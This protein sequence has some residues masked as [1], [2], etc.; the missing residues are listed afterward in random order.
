MRGPPAPESEDKEMTEETSMK[1]E[2]RPI[3]EAER[4]ADEWFSI[5]PKFRTK[6][7]LARYFQCA[8]DGNREALK[9][10]VVGKS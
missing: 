6:A 3:T 5:A 10:G 4:L 7:Y 2:M 9:V 1:N 8:I